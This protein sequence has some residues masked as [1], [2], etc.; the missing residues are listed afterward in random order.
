IWG[1][2][3]PSHSKFGPETGVSNLGRASHL[4]LVIWDGRLDPWDGCLKL[5]KLV[6]MFL[7]EK[8]DRTPFIDVLMH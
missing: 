5:F 2:G 6:F 1:V 3:R 8:E 4:D 7:D